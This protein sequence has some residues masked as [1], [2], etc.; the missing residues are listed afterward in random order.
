MRDNAI[1]LLEDGFA[2]SGPVRSTGGE[3]SGSRNYWS[4]TEPARRR[5]R[6]V[7]RSVLDRQ[8]QPLGSIRALAPGKLSLPDLPA[9]LDYDN[10]TIAGDWTDCGFNEGCVE[11]AVMSGRLAAHAISRYPP[12]D[13]IVGYDHP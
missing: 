2:T 11:A 8:R 13:E 5:D 4:T 7:R 6:R 10:L 12:L 1:A 9:R 3:G